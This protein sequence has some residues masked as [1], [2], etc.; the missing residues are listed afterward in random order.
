MCPIIA[1]GS[2]IS[3]ASGSSAAILSVVSHGAHETDK[4]IFAFTLPERHTS[5][6]LSGFGGLIGHD[7]FQSRAASSVVEI[8]A[9]Q[10]FFDECFHV[11]LSISST[12]VAGPDS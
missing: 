2:H 3:I 8:I 10:T 11:V 7:Q 12:T 4:L 9:R 5:N 6:P 1:T